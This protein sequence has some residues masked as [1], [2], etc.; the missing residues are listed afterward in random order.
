MLTSP[1]ALDPVSTLLGDV[2][3]TADLDHFGYA[4]HSMTTT[5]LATSAGLRRRHD[6]PSARFELC[7]KSHGR[8]RSA[9]AGRAGRHLADLDL[10][11][12]PDEVRA[13]V[14]R[15]GPPG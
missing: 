3:P 1:Q 5:Y 15:T 7:G 12:A 9:W 14:G 8:T 2:L 4:E 10:A 11:S 13:A 6:Q